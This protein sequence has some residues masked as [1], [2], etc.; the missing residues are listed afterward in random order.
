M[1][2][3]RYILA[4]TLRFFVTVFLIVSFVFVLVRIIPGDPATVIA[5]PEAGAADVALI[6]ARLGTDRPLV[7]QY[8]AWSC[9]GNSCWC[10][11][12]QLAGSSACRAFA[13]ASGCSGV[14]A[15]DSPFAGFLGAFWCIPT[16]WV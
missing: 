13:P 1:L 11:K 15:G 8:G 3:W 9:V 7:F 4:K 14:L 12:G 5:G 2:S 16:L 10:K 6:R